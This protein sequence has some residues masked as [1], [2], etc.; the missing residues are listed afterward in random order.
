MGRGET[1]AQ[2]RHVC[3]G[4]RRARTEIAVDGDMKRPIGNESGTG[5]AGQESGLRCSWPRAAVAL[6]VLIVLTCPRLMA[7]E[8]AAEPLTLRVWPNVCAEPCTIRV[9]VRAVRDEDNRSLNVEVDSTHFFRSSTE[10]L[11]GEEAAALHRMVYRGLPAGSYRVSATVAGIDGAETKV[12]QVIVT[13]SLAAV[14]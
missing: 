6:A 4:D 13:G 11:H 10:Q 7:A 5:K 1:A 3:I 9:T 2:T 14:N 8:D 12:H